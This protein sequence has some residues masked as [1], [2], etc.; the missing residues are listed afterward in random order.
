MIYPQSEG[1]LK[2]QPVKPDLI[3]PLQS[4]CYGFKTKSLQVWEYLMTFCVE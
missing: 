2:H 1:I 3:R 4:V